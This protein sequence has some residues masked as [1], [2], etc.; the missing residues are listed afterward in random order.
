MWLR[1]SSCLK[2]WNEKKEKVGRNGGEG[3]RGAKRVLSTPMDI[4]CP[5]AGGQDTFVN[6]EPA[7]GD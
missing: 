4:V 2:K 5:V 6:A 3:K 1:N 7:V